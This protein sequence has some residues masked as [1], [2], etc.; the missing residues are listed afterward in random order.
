MADTA[1]DPTLQALQDLDTPGR[2]IVRAGVPIF[3]EHDD[4]L[5]G[6]K[7]TR[8]K[9][10]TLAR[11]TNRREAEEGVPMSIV[12]GHTPGRKEEEIQHVGYARHLRVGR[13]GPKKKLGILADFYYKPECYEKAKQ[14]PHRSVERWVEDAL[15]DPVSLL[16]RTP[17]LDLGL[18][19]PDDGTPLHKKLAVSDGCEL[20]VYHRAGSRRLY[21]MS[22]SPAVDDGG[23]A[24]TREESAPMDP[25]QLLMEMCDGLEALIQKC[26]AQA[27]PDDQPQDTPG[28]APA[29][30]PEEVQTYGAMPSGTN[31]HMPDL[32]TY[33]KEQFDA[34]K[35]DLE[36][37]QLERDEAVR[38]YQRQGRQA[39]L[40]ALKTDGYTLDVEEELTETAAFDKAA[41]DKHVAKIK[42]CYARTGK[43]AGT[44]FI[45]TEGEERVTDA[46]ESSE[47]TEYAKFAP[48]VREYA[49]EKNIST[50]EAWERIKRD[51]VKQ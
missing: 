45:P 14:F 38:L 31:T 10:E 50:F 51:R 33:S 42:K 47:A 16:A 11:N 21:Q 27:T 1:T 41:F 4:P 48:E 5:T 34:V 15:L 37:A 46:T 2:F 13:F 36:K 18:L 7:W 8:A 25:Q 19:L 43:S 26:R 23:I 49:K 6:E 39:A 28:A 20:M 17:Q 22:D 29:G 35:A 32:I 44:T 12:I 9:L 24:A 40:N 30:G 3:C